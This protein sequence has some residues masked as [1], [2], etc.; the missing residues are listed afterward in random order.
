GRD[1]PSASTARGLY[2]T[3][4]L[5][6]LRV[7]EI[8][9]APKPTSPATRQAAGLLAYL[10]LFLTTPGKLESVG[11]SQLLVLASCATMVSMA[12]SWGWRRAVIGS[13]RNASFSR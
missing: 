6:T 9:L 10:A 13:I 4:N 2:P 12:L 11:S 8:T 1:L 7:D 3:T 5:R